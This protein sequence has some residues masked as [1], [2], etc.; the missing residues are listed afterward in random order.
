MLRPA[1]P[2]SSAI[3]PRPAGSTPTSCARR[4]A[5]LVAAGWSRRTGSPGVRAILLADAGRARAGD[6]RSS[7]AG[8]WCALGDP[9]LANRCRAKTRSSCRLDAAAPLR[10]RLPAAARPARPT[11]RRGASWRASTPARGPRRD[12]RRPLRHR[13]VRR[14]VRAAPTPSSGCARS[15]ARRRTG[16]RR[17]QRRRPAEPH[18]HRHRRRAHPHRHSHPTSSIATAFRSRSSK[19]IRSVSW[20]RSPREPCRT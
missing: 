14:A 18:R 5:T 10:R 17:D 16:A 6:R 9:R 20:R 7:F 3:S 4:S 8:R 19:A 11:P 12:P 15:A 1:A 13:H 2:C